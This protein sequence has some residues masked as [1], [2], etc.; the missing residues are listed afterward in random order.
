MSRSTRSHAASV[1]AL[2]FA[3]FAAATPFAPALPPDVRVE[4]PALRLRGGG[5][6]T[7]FGLSVYDG[8]YWSVERGFSFAQPFAL[9]L[10]YRRGFEGRRIA[11]RSVDEM[12][13]LGYGTDGERKRWGDAMTR[14]FPDVVKGDRLTGFY[15]PEGGVRYF[16]NGAPIGEI[17]DPAFARA[18]FAIWFDPRSSR[19]DFR[20]MLLGD[21]P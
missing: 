9:D 21:A 8:Y 5:E 12:E 1:A 11:S 3:T 2:A 6:M 18:F 16:L 17:V 14:I 13:K 7:F 20:R 15:V 19:A 4:V 10:T